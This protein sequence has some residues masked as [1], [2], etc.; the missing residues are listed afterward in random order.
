MKKISALLASV[1][2]LAVIT[3]CGDKN[4]DTQGAAP[5]AAATTAASASPK[6]EEK[7]KLADIKKAGKI[8]M[9]TSADYAPYEFHKL[10][11]GKDMIVGFDIEIAKAI[12]ADMGV[13]LEIKDMGFDGLLPALAAGNVDF[14]MSGMTPTEERKKNVDFS[15]VY[16]TAEQIVL[17]RTEDKDKFKTIDDLKKAN[18]GVQTASIQEGLA[19]EQLEGAKLKS[20]GKIPDLVLELK[21]KKIDALIMEKPVATGYT[22]KHT[23][24][25]I[26]GLSLNAEDAGSAA[27]VKKGNPELVAQIDKTLERLINEKAIEQFVT[28]AYNLQGEQ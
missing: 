17:V 8:V 16:Y 5:T 9:G 27:A 18:V 23:D 28:E 26:S 11:E 13:T 6:A 2:L 15:K 1:M 24:V 20:I 14:V 10:I 7:G 3:A 25:V 21:N 22:S 19:K 4:N 12:A